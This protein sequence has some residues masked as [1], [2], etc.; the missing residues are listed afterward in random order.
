MSMSER[1]SKLRKQSLEEIETLSSERAELMTE[2][3]KQ[4]TWIGLY[5]CVQSFGI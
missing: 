2:F 4:D 5:T 3:Y 1:V